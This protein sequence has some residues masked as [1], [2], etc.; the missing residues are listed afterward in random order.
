MFKQLIR[1]YWEAEVAAS[2]TTFGEEFS[3]SCT[4]VK[5]NCVLLTGEIQGCLA[6]SI[7]IIRNRKKFDPLLFSLSANV[8]T[9]Q[10]WKSSWN[11]KISSCLEKGEVS[12]SGM[13]SN[14]TPQRA[15]SM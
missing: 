1:F 3:F 8:H 7:Y 11:G 10:A 2:Y 12:H 9:K 13:S 15:A 6:E 4:K 14:R 5:H